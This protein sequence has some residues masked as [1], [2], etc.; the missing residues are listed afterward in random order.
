MHGCFKRV[1]IFESDPK[2]AVHS[3]NAIYTKLHTA[4][5]AFLTSI[6]ADTV[7]SLLCR[8]KAYGLSGGTVYKA[9]NSYPVCVLAAKT[10]EK[11]RF[12]IS[13]FR[14]L[15][16]LAERIRREQP[17]PLKQQMPSMHING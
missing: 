7:S 1:R 16:F 15:S 12:C 9:G 13:V 17:I 14:R 10:N 11:K 8:Q 6:G 4:A 3:A 2:Y 5:S